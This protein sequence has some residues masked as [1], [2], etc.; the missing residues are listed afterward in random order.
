[1]RRGAWRRARRRSSPPAP[2]QSNYAR[3]D[4]RPR[5]GR[6]GARGRALP[7][8]RQRAPGNLT[9]DAIFG[10]T[11]VWD[12]DPEA[13]ASEIPGAVVLPY[14]VEAH[15][16][17]ARYLACAADTP[18]SRL[19][20]RGTSSGDRLRRHDGRPRRRPRRRARARRR[21]RRRAGPGRDRR[22]LR[23]RTRRGRRRPARCGSTRSPPATSSSTTAPARRSRP[24]AG[25][26]AWS[27]SRS[28]RPRPW[29]A[30]ERRSRTATSSPVTRPYSSTPAASRVSSVT[31][32]P[33]ARAAN[34]PTLAQRHQR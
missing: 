29:R 31:R 16:R 28:T 25:S 24:P 3:A 21:H 9:L 2:P 4:A 13:I 7:T 26:R 22:R 6:L 19:R 12:G 8:S 17:R 27:W 34:V 23:H 18:P 5:R 15:E 11:V 14:A 33:P 30:S 32:T 1:M 10:A 20:T